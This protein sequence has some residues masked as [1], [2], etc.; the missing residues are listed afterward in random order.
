MNNRILHIV[1]RLT[2]SMMPL[3]NSTFGATCLHA[4]LIAIGFLFSLGT[5][6]S[7]EASV[8]ANTT[9]WK[10]ESNGYI[11]IRICVDPASNAQQKADGAGGGLAHQTNPSIDEVIGR[12]RGALSNSWEKYSLVRFIGWEGCDT[13]APGDISNVVRLL[14]QPD[15]DNFAEKL[16]KD[17]LGK[18]VQF[19]AW[20]KSFNRCISY[21]WWHFREEY[22]FDCAEQYAIHEFGHVLGF[23]HEWLH[24]LAPASCPNSTPTT[25]WAPTYFATKYVNTV[26]NPAY[27]YHSVMTY[28]DGCVEQDGVRFG[29]TTVN[30]NDIDGL[31]A[32]YPVLVV[33]LETTE[34]DFGG[35]YGYI[36]GGTAVNNPATNSQTCP[37]QYTAQQVF[38][39]SGTDWPVFICYRTHTSGTPSIY[40]FGGMWGYV[41]NGFPAVNPLTGQ[42]SCRSD[43]IDLQVLGTSGTDWPLHVCY[44]NHGDN[45][46][47]RFGGVLGTVNTRA[48]ANQVTL[49]GECAGGYQQQAV[50]GTSDVDWPLS[51]CYARSPLKAA[52]LDF[53]GAYGYING[54]TAVNN[55]ATG[56]QTCPSGYTAQQVF[57]TSGT[58]WPVFV[59]YRAH[60]DGDA[61]F[62]DFGG[63]WGYVNGVSTANPLTGQSSC[64]F[65]FTDLQVLGTSGTDWPLH[66]CYRTP[67]PGE[68]LWFGGIIGTVNQT[69]VSNPATGSSSCPVDYLQ[70][71]VLGTD[72]VD[73]PLSYCY[74]IPPA[75]P[76][77]AKK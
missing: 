69:T 46:P 56:L 1:R 66:V 31:R 59:C 17:I 15:A 38:G 6:A 55:S 72:N 68:P 41:N 30:Q 3:R 40:D 19:A 21:N 5:V 57:G 73:W 25:S 44:R 49:V 62:Y 42:A 65:E 47:L 12:V 26:P 67:I 61:P 8:F 29:S 9:Q 36:N 27:D 10:T 71:A 70:Q 28:S 76:T 11:Y 63:M 75:V 64:P 2:V 54:G 53:G 34:L 58:D 43:F 50:L 7:S 16:G 23:E 33:P 74:A 14:V 13:L 22:S 35:A 48:V 24:P 18:H 60:S 39:T 32:V 4:I 45:P 37:S 52:G 77:N 20:G 51:Y